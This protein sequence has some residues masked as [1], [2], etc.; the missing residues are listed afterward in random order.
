MATTSTISPLS[1]M[2]AHLFTPFGEC[3]AEINA[4]KKTY[5]DDF[6]ELKAQAEREIAAG[7]VV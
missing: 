1:Y 7:G 4:F 6:A 2:R 5:P 3:V